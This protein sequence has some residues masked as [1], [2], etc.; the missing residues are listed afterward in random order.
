MLKKQLSQTYA[1]T[2]FRSKLINLLRHCLLCH[3]PFPQESSQLCSSCESK[4]WQEV[5]LQQATVRTDMPFKTR[6]LLDWN[7][8][9]HFF[10]KDLAYSLKGA[11][12]TALYSYF[13]Q[14][15]GQAENQK[16]P[17][18]FLSVPSKD[19]KRDHAYNIAESLGSQS[20]C[21]FAQAPLKKFAVEPL[22]R[23]NRKERLSQKL[24]V[25]NSKKE[26]WVKDV[27]KSEGKVILIDDIVTTGATLQSS[28][29]ALG[30]PKN[31]EA[32]TLFSK[33]LSF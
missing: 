14:F 21:I 26:K 23:M 22:K 33:S 24:F 6:Y 28:W 16:N 3:K 31:L 7:K 17:M 5:L 29:E 12:Q 13:T 11:G 4:V 1:I 9:N 18:I 19:G 25:K 32:W 8:N 30:R 10:C 20:G 15:F 2:K 27:L